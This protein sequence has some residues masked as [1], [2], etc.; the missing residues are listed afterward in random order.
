MFKDRNNFWF[1]Y[2]LD[3]VGGVVVG[4]MMAGFLYAYFQRVGLPHG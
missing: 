4:L 3:L 1:K 2:G